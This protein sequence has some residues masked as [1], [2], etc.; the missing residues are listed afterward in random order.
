MA[1]IPLDEGQVVSRTVTVLKA[2]VS[3]NV[4]DNWPGP[5]KAGHRD[6]WKKHLVAGF[7]EVQLPTGGVRVACQ[8]TL[9]FPTARRR[10]FQNYHHPLWYYVADALVDYGVIPDDT[11]EYFSIGA[12][13]GITFAVDNRRFVAED[14][15]KRVVLGIAV[16]MP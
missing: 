2:A 15:R 12:N 6:S 10:D 8:A 11:P 7:E 9:V 3:K 1:L 5:W 4:Y 13:G 16:Q 14:K